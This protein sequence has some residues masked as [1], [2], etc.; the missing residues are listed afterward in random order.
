LRAAERAGRDVEPAAVESGHRDLKAKSFLAEP[1]TGR[2]AHVLKDDGARRLRVPAH[3]ALVGAEG[4]AGGVA[5]HDKRRNA[6]GAF[7]AAPRHHHIKIARAGAGDELLLPV[8]D[9]MVA[10]THRAG[11]KRRRIR[12]DAR[13]GQ[14]VACQ[15]LHRAQ[16]RQ[17]LVALLLRA[18][19]V[20]QRRRHIVDRHISGNR[21]TARRQS[22]ENQSRGQPRQAG[23]AGILG[24]EDSAHAKRCGLAHLGDGKVPGLVP[25][26]R[27]GREMLIGKGARHVARGDLVGVERKLE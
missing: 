11:G 24:D 8:E 4:N 2:D 19:G 17:P 22:F 10:V 3:L 20:D 13:L 6:R 12:P 1:V 16:F 25:E 5:R 23:A 14:A 18:E 9:V 7:A 26:E 21:R 27:V 15:E